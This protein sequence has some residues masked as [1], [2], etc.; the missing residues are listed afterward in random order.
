[1]GQSQADSPS[2]KLELEECLKPSNFLL[3]ASVAGE[4]GPGDIIDGS[5]VATLE[6][7]PPSN[8]VPL[9]SSLGILNFVGSIRAHTSSLSSGSYLKPP[10]CSRINIPFNIIINIVYI[11]LYYKYN[12]KLFCRIIYP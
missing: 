4:S 8:K 1:M 3:R 11:L 7:S 6:L 9:V 10:D 5:L 12:I 2:P